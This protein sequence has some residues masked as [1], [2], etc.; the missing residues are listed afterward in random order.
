MTV[1]GAVTGV[2]NGSTRVSITT[3]SGKGLSTGE[4][5]A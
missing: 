3:S 4:V 2:L 1:I 5:L